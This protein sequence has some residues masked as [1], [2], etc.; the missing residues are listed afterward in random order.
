MLGEHRGGKN[1]YKRASWKRWH[2]SWVLKCKYEFS[3]QR[4]GNR[5]FQTGREQRLQGPASGQNRGA[6]GSSEQ[7]GVAGE[8][9]WQGDG[10]EVCC[11][12]A[13]YGKTVDGEGTHACYTNWPAAK[14]PPNGFKTTE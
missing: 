1:S 10:G 13:S 3:G 11:K 2:L 9:L 7:Y 5:A 12:G 6:F 4:G 14:K 8:R